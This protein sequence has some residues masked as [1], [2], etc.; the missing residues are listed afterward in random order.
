MSSPFRRVLGIGFDDKIIR[1][2]DP[3]ASSLTFAATGGGKTTAVGV[4]AVQSMLA[5]TD[6]ALL[7]NDVK[8]GEIGG[9]R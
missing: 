9:D 4:P 1:E 8:N 7:V 3:S 6:R 5:D 2:P